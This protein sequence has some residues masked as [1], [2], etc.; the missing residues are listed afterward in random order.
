MKPVFP[1]TQPL[2]VSSPGWLIA[3]RGASLAIGTLALLAVAEVVRF[4]MAASDIWLISPA[5]V[6]EQLLLAILAAGGT[7]SILF[8][9]RGALP[10][11]IRWITVLLQLALAGAVGRDLAT[12]F[13]LRQSGL[14]M[15]QPMSLAMMLVLAISGLIVSSRYPNATGRKLIV[16][17]CWAVAI[18]GFLISAVNTGQLPDSDAPVTKSTTVVFGDDVRPSTDAHSDA[19]SV[20]EQ[21]LQHACFLV[22]EQRADRVL[23]C[24]AAL[25]DSAIQAVIRT[26]QIPQ[27]SVV[28]LPPT[29]DVESCLIQ[30]IEIAA[31]S[32]S[33]TL[34][35]F[36]PQICFRRVRIQCARAGL[37]GVCLMDVPPPIT[38]PSPTDVLQEA[39]LLGELLL[40]PLTQW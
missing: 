28:R 20:S 33:P 5:G 40:Q 7:G 18:V 37:N 12:A 27:E 26:E 30:A 19:S 29:A 16:L 3:S 14:E 34:V 35:F 15:Y 21:R 6:P 31:T 1:D 25:D 11:P 39:R 9:M 38:A 13:Q 10:A 22:R 23:A 36:G 2:T 32:D 8:G 17:F 24:S 4:Q